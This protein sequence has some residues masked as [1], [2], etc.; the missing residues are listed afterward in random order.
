MLTVKFTR[1]IVYRAEEAMT[2]MR[3]ISITLL[4]LTFRFTLNLGTLYV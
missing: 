3:V 1:P 2:I 4:N